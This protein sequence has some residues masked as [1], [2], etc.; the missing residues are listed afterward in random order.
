MPLSTIFQLYRGDQFYWKRKP[1]DPEKTTEMSQFTE[2]LYQ[3]KGQQ[4]RKNQ[5]TGVS[6]DSMLFSNFHE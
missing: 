3:V 6:F 1:E 2:I 5:S 4:K